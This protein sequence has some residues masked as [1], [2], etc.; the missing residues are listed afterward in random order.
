METLAVV[1]WLWGTRYTVR[2]VNVL[3]H[4][5]DRTLRIPFR[6]FVFSDRPL[7][8]LDRGIKRLTLWRDF[9]CRRTGCWVRL[10][11]FGVEMRELVGPRFLSLDLDLV[12]LR[13]I[14]PLV[15]RPEPLVLSRSAS[16]AHPDN[17]YS[18]TMWL[19]KSGA[20]AETWQRFRDHMYN[21]GSCRRLQTSLKHRGYNGTD[22]AWLSYDLGPGI[23]TWGKEDGVYSFI[24]DIEGRM[25]QP[26]EDAR[27]VLFHGRKYDPADPELQAAHPWIEEYWC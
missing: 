3:K 18:G 21:W 8:G 26:P 12:L 14:T 2:H 9:R 7:R 16:P 1:T 5:L 15:D 13:D 6:M 19:L 10:R 17:L 23:P 4:M 25:D 22:S 11:S 24:W 27:I 20:F